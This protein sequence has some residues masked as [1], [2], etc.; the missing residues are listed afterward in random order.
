MTAEEIRKI[1][2]S[3]VENHIRREIAAQLAESNAILSAQLSEL[4]GSLNAIRYLLENS[5]ASPRLRHSGDST[6]SI[7][8]TKEELG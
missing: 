6:R 4:N 5:S 3:H 7:R 2:A 8:G 1:N